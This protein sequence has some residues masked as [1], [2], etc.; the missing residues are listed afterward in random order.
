MHNPANSFA[1]FVSVRAAFRPR[2]ANETVQTVRGGS[3][4]DRFY[5]RLQDLSSTWSSE[6]HR[7]D[8]LVIGPGEPI[9]PSAVRVRLDLALVCITCVFL[10]AALLAIANA[11]VPV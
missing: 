7:T 10:S 6:M 8:V 1:L 11:G 4:K 3:V 5:A 9:L 2:N